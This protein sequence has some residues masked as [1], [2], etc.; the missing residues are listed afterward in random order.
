M[1]GDGATL[2]PK[3]A[4]GADIKCKNVIMYDGFMYVISSLKGLSWILADLS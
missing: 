2:A 1:F 3:S 4:S